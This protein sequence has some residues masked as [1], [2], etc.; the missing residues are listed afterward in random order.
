MSEE[1]A[2]GLERPDGKG[3][4]VHELIL[5]EGLIREKTLLMNQRG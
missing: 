5:I 3:G 1:I 4:D 2:V